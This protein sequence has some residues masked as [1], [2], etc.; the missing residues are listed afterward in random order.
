M[1]SEDDVDSLIDACTEVAGDALRSVVSFTEDDF[2]QISLR[3]YLSADADVQAFVENER[4]GFHRTPTHEG[5]ELG[6][7]EY[8][9]RRFAHGYLV[10]V[11]ADGHGVYVT[12][13][14]MPIERFD[15]LAGAVERELHRLESGDEEG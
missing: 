2:D 6:R 12:T 13:N 15:E 14:R 10:R 4:E 3:D 9:I 8:T 1:L 7:Y 5:S 11:I